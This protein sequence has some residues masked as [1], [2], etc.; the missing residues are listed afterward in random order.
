M[1]KRLPAMRETWV[2]FLGREDPLAKEMAIHSGILVWKIPWTEEPGRLHPMGLQR[3]RHDWATSLHF[4]IIALPLLML[5][6]RVILPSLNT[7]IS[8][9]WQEIAYGFVEGSRKWSGIFLSSLLSHDQNLKKSSCTSDGQIFARRHTWIERSKQTRDTR[10]WKGIFRN[11][12]FL[13]V[14]C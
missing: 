11:N 14:M 5:N 12:C 2:R 10:S 1:V 4:S 8:T 7:S 6:C 9:T 3:V 13:V